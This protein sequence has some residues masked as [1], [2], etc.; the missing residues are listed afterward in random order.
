MH[1]GDVLVKGYAWIW[2][3][4]EVG[5]AHSVAQ[6]NQ[7]L[8]AGLLLIPSLCDMLTE[9]FWMVRMG[10]RGRAELSLSVSALSISGEQDTAI[11][12]DPAVPKFLIV[13]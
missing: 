7:W 6:L 2:R 1:C 11:P 10:Q 3:I 9:E 8:R 5:G 12:V 4:L 13:L